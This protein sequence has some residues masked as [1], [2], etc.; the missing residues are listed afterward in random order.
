MH[1]LIGLLETGQV[2][3]NG[4]GGEATLPF[5]G[6]K[7]SGYGRENGLIGLSAFTKIKAIRLGY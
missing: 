3:V 6:V 4:G 2:I 7:Q 1:G 5:G